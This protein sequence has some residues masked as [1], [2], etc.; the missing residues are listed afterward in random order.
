MQNKVGRRDGEN[1]VHE[2][3]NLRMLT[4]NSGGERGG[5]KLC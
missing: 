5:E 4:E 1:R 2:V 3:F